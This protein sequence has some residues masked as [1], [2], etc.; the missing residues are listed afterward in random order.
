MKSVRARAGQDGDLSAW[1]AT[2]FGSISR[3][4]DCKFLKSVHGNEPI[5]AARLCEGWQ[6]PT[7]RLS[8]PKTYGLPDIRADA[9]DHEVVGVGPLTVDVELP[10]LVVIGARN[11]NARG[12]LEQ[13]LERPAVQG[14]FP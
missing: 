10:L 1:G 14:K 11:H 6:R 12:Q 4:L 5:R 7:Y 8:W 2:E 9:I 13:G 3:G